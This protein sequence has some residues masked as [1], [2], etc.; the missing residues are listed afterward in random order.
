MHIFTLIVVLSLSCQKKEET[1]K[2]L[3]QPA[4]A[5]AFES[6]IAAGL[7]TDDSSL[8]DDET[9]LAD[10]ITQFFTGDSVTIIKSLFE[11]ID[12]KMTNLSG[13]A[14]NEA[15]GVSCVDDPTLVSK[16]FDD[17]IVP[18]DNNLSH[19]LHCT[20]DFEGDAGTGFTAFGKID[21]NHVAF[22]NCKPDIGY[23]SDGNCHY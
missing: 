4:T 1:G 22:S 18:A 21:E 5:D 7:L 15:D 11:D 10:F 23:R 12:T 8:D 14:R 17:D 13:D 20:K 16:S 2:G 9:V 3:G 6:I 19:K